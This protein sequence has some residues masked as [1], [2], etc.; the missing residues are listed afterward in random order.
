MAI[1]AENAHIDDATSS[2]RLVAPLWRNKSDIMSRVR[3]LRAVIR[4]LRA[5]KTGLCVLVE[6]RPFLVT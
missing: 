3:W 6:E 1:A 4:T 5:D 2:D